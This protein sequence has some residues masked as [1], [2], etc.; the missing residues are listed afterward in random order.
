MFHLFSTF[1]LGNQ[2][3][4]LGEAGASLRESE[5]KEIDK[6]KVMKTSLIDSPKNGREKFGNLSRQFH[7]REFINNIDGYLH[8]H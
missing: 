8:N 5:Y 3:I 1:S 6:Y 7:R 2:K 4:D